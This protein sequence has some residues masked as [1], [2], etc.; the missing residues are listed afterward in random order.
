MNL[1]D[2]LQYFRPDDYK[3]YYEGKKIKEEEKEAKKSG[4][5]HK[6]GTTNEKETRKQIQESSTNITPEQVNQI[7]EVFDQ[8][9]KR[10]SS[11]P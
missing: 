6:H 10:N 2:I 5:V 4:G 7:N 8:Y 3:V 9:R 11:D 1:N